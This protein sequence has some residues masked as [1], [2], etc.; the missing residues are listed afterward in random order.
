[1]TITVSD[2][3]AADPTL[4]APGAQPQAGQVLSDGTF[5]QTAGAVL[6]LVTGE[7]V[8]LG[9][10]TLAQASGGIDG[11]VELTD[12]S[13]L[14]FTE[15]T[16]SAARF[17]T[18][19]DPDA[20][21]G[22]GPAVVAG[23]QPA[24]GYSSNLVWPLEAGEF[25]I[26]FNSGGILPFQELNRFG[27]DLGQI[28]TSLFGWN[29]SQITGFAEL[30][31]LPGGNIALLSED[32]APAYTVDIISRSGGPINTLSVGSD[33]PLLVAT[34]DGFALIRLPV[35]GGDVIMEVYD[36]SGLLTATQN[37]SDPLGGA[38][39]VGTLGEAVMLPDGTIAVTYFD[40]GASDWVLCRMDP[41]LLPGVNSNLPRFVVGSQYMHLDPSGLLTLGL[42][43]DA[44]P[45]EWFRPDRVLTSDAAGDVMAGTAAIESFRGNAGIDTVDYSATRIG[46][47][48]DLVQGRG[49][50]QTWSASAFD[51]YEGTENVTG[52][53][54]SDRITGNG[55]ANLLRGMAGNDT[56]QG[57]A[58][59]D[60][61]DGGTG[62]DRLEGGLGNDTYIVDALGDLV[63]G[64][65]GFG[66]GGGIDTVT[67]SVDFTAPANV[68]ILR[69]AVGVAGVD[70]T[71]NDA[72][73]TLVGN[74][75]ANVLNGRG[76]NDQLNGNA[77]DDKLIGGEGVDTL[78]GGLG[79]D[80]FVYNAVSN[81]RAGVGNRDVL[82]GFDRGAVQDRIDLSAID[83]NTATAA[84]DAFTF[85]G[86]GP[87]TGAGQVRVLGLGG[88]NAVIV[89]VN[90]NADL[91][92]DM[93][94]F[95]NLTTTMGLGDFVL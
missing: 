13:L 86:T 32:I 62:S 38:P 35:S 36:S 79:A 7:G 28:G 68:E 27:S 39:G 15:T 66:A 22:G 57:G 87:F 2:A 4:P 49:F 77:G 95:V 5:V 30:A 92:A 56:L 40:L 61:L 50:G 21:A 45:R 74:A 33:R 93:Q 46:V 80:T 82:N 85:I 43:P 23:P 18:V 67:T 88:P 55:L 75:F 54:A 71:G 24:P 73:G 63:Q 17:M 76:G 90:V 42:D 37:V 94:I 44:G 25:L 29:D 65:A 9:S 64:E 14:V 69:A 10:L 16:G 91:A 51:R 70:L 31:L 81:S 89:E 12:G 84:N 6:S 3:F 26:L 78:A 8:L 58:G 59:D 11:I 60:R 72:P 52:S 48:V 83:A 20:A 41:G 47:V 34:A 19:I 1:M 53:Q